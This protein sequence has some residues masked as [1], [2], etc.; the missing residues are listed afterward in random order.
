M[1]EQFGA[2]PLEA[3]LT[4]SFGCCGVIARLLL[5][6]V[7][8]IAAMTL[9]LVL[10]SGPPDRW[11]GI[12][13]SNMHPLAL[14][15]DSR[16]PETVYAGTEQGRI[17]ITHDGGQTWHETGAGLPANTPVS[18]LAQLPDG[19]QILAGTS[20]GA[21]RSADGGQ[22]WRSAGPGIPAHAI[23]DAVAALPDGTLLA[24]TAGSGVYVMP[25]GTTMWVPASKGLPSQSDIY[26]FLPLGQ[27]G[28][29]LVGLISGGIYASEDDGTTWIQ[30]DQGLPNPSCRFQRKCEMKW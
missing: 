15:T 24:G 16:H 7:L 1:A 4:E 30:S 13:D 19:S 23:V 3:S 18:A 14:I 17:L 25:S 26:A 6:S 12:A 21:Y 28:H 11:Q 22:T 27:R 10:V 9:G 8:A 20:N 29:V 2:S 5:A